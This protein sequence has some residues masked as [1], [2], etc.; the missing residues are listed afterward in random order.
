ML[1]LIGFGRAFQLHDQEKGELFKQLREAE[2]L[3]QGFDD[4]IKKEQ[5]RRGVRFIGGNFVGYEVGHACTFETH[6]GRE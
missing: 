6:E 5:L 2:E 4:A 1:R 3:S